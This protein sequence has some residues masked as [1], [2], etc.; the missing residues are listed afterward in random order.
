MTATALAY[1]MPMAQERRETTARFAPARLAEDFPY[2]PLRSQTEADNLMMI[3]AAQ[4]GESAAWEAYFVETLTEFLLFRA[5]P[6]ARVSA[7]DE[8]WLLASMGEEPSPS[9]PALMKALVAQAEDLSP[10]LM[11]CARRCDAL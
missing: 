10:A 6:T 5:R 8:A 2:R 11:A 4:S 9:L 3:D 7:E 1:A